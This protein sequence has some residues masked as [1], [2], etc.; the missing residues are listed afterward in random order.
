MNIIKFFIILFFFSGFAFAQNTDTGRVNAPTPAKSDSSTTILQQNQNTQN[1]KYPKS[2]YNY[3]KNKSGE[4]EQSEL[5]EKLYY[6]CNIALRFYSYNGSSVFYYDLSPHVGYKFTDVLS[7][8]LQIIYNN[9]VLTRGNSS[10]SYNVVGAGVFGRVIVYKYLFLQAEYDLL[11]VPQ[12]YLGTAVLHRTESDEK[13][14]GLGYKS[15]LGKKLSY[16]LVLMF[17]FNPTYYSPYYSNP[18]VY[19]AGLVYNF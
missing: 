1:R 16:Y 7:A 3:K 17:D 8:G 2:Y 4:E 15:Q 5:K 13:M 9:S 11:S 19:R 10:V 18:L 12:Y 6:G 14:A